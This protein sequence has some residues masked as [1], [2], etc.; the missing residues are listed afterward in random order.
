MTQKYVYD[1]KTNSYIPVDENQDKKP[2]SSNTND[3]KLIAILI[4]AS[5]FLM[6]IVGGIIA[7]VYYENKNEFLRCTGKESL[8]FGISAAIYGL[9]AFMLSFVFI[10]FI[11][12]PLI[13]IYYLVIPI[14]GLL[15]ASEMKVYKPHFT[16]RFI[17]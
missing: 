13:G 4:W 16:I 14:L 6:P 15:Q 17:K 3:E 11:L 12:I 9:V 1:E 2:G 10:G 8:N 7:Y 5:N